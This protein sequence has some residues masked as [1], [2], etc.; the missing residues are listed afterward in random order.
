MRFFLSEEEFRLLSDDAAAVAERA[1]SALRDLHR[2][3]DTVRAESDA[4]SIAAEQN[5][6]LLEQRYEALSSDLAR[7]QAENA[8]LSESLEQRLSEIAAALAEKHQLHIKAIAKDGDIER[9]SL[10]AQELGKSKQHL[11]DLLEQ[12]DAE[13]REKNATVQSY[14]DKIINMTDSATEKEARLLDLEAEC[15]RCKAICIRVNQEKELIEKHNAWLNEELSTK[16]NSLIE[17]RKTHL[18][19]V[20]DMSA[21]LSEYERQ[22]NECSSSLKHS[23]ERVGELEL[24]NASIEKELFSSKD[25]AAAKEEQLISELA[26]VRKL[27]ELHKERSEEWSKKS[28]E[29]EGVIK[30]LE[31]HLSQHEN[32]YKD[33]LEK[34]SSLRKN[35]EKDAADMKEKLEKYE[36][37]LDRARKSNELSLVPSSFHSD[38]SLEVLPVAQTTT[39]EN[40]HILVPKI[41]FGISGT[42]LAASLLRDGWSLAKMYEKYQEA[43]DALQHEKWGRKNAE[44]ALERV[45]HE[46]E[47]KAEMIL[48]ERA[49]HGRMI[50][51]YNL[52][53]QKLQ[54]SLIDYDNFENTIRNLKVTILLKECQDIQVRCGVTSFYADNTLISSVNIDDPDVGRSTSEYPVS[55]KDIHGLVEQ[56]VQLRGQ[57]LSLSTEIENKEVDLKDTFEFQLQ[58]ITAEATSKVETVLKRSEEQNQMI[59][60][61]HGSVAMYRRLYEEEQ[62]MH[63]STNASTGKFEGVLKFT[64]RDHQSSYLLCSYFKAFEAEDG[65]KDLM[66][67]F[68]GSQDVSKK[69]YEQL[70]ERA[71]NLEEDLAKF[72]SEVALLRSERDK[73]A[74]EAI[75]AKD[76]LDDLKKEIERQPHT[77][78]IC[79]EWEIVILYHVNF[80]Y[81]FLTVITVKLRNEA[82]VGSTRNLELTQLVVDFQKR[83]RESSNSVQEAEENARKLSME[84]S[85]LKHEKE[86]ISN[87]EKRALDE[88]RNLSERVHRL[89]A[90]LDTIQSSEEV[91]E[92]SRAIGMKKLEEYSKRVEREWAEA[93]GEL[94]E[95]RDRLR[96]L[97]NDKENILETSIKQFQEMKKE[98]A[99][100]WGAVASAESRAAVAEARCSEFELRMKTAEEKV[101]KGDNIYEHRVFSPNEDTGDIRRVREELE[102]LREE[103][104]AN[105]DYM[106]QY[107]EIAHTNEIA[108][109]QIES[110]YETYKIEAESVKKALDDEVFSLKD[111][112]SELEKKYVLKCEEILSL[113]EVKDR[114]ISALFAETS[115]LRMEIAQK[116]TQIDALETQLSSL[117]GDLDRE[118]ERWRTTQHNYERQVILQS[119]TIQELTKTSNE[120]SLMQCEIAKLKEVSDMQKSENE[121]LK[122]SWENDKTTLNAM[123]DEAEKKYNELN[124]QNKILH[125]QLESLHIRFAEKERNSAGLSS[126]SVDL[127]AESDLHN[128]ITYLRRSKEIAETEIT[129]LK[130][131]KSRL[132]AQLDSALKASEAAKELLH[133]RRENNRALMFNDEEFKAL[134][135]QIRE[136][137]LLRESNVQLRE[138]N[139]HNFEECQRYRDE[140][141]KA[142][143]DAET[144]EN[145]LREK[146]LQY[147]YSQ[148]DVNILR[149]E[150]NHLNNRIAEVL[151]KK[152]EMEIEPIKKLVSDKQEIISKLTE[153]LAKSELD[154][155]E[156]ER[157]IN[158]AVQIEGTIKTESERQKKYI[159][160]LKKKNENITKENVELNQ[161]KETLLKEIEEFKSARKTPGETSIEQATKE[162]DTRI[163][164]LEKILER[165]REENKKEKQKRQNTEKKIFEVIQRVSKEKKSLTEELSRH[166]LAVEVLKS[167][168]VATSQLPSE[169]TLIEQYDQYIQ[170][171]T[172][173]ENASGSMADD[174]LG[175]PPVPVTETSASEASVF[176]SVRQVPVQVARPLTSPVKSAEEKEKGPVIGRPTTAATRKIPARK[177]VRPRLEP[178]E[179]PQGDNSASGMEGSAPTEDDKAGASHE[180]EPSS[181]ILVGHSISSSRKSLSS[182]SE[183]KDDV[184]SK[185]EVGADAVPL[186][187]KKDSDAVQDLISLAQPVPPNHKRPISTTEDEI[188]TAAAAPPL[189]K[190]KD[191]DMLQDV[192]QDLIDEKTI[193]LSAEDE[194]AET[195]LPSS[196][197]V[198]DLQSPL[199]DME[200]DQVPALPNEEIV[201]TMEEDDSFAREEQVEQQNTL[202]ESTH[203]DEIQGE[204]ETAPEDF[205]DNSKEA[206]E[207]LDDSVKN[208]GVKEISQPPPTD[209][210][211]REEGELPDEPEEQQE[212]G[213]LGEGQRESTPSD[214]AGLGDEAGFSIDTVPPDQ[215]GIGEATDEVPSHNNEDQFA[216]DSLQ[217]TLALSSA[218]REG[219]PSSTLVSALAQQQIASSTADTDESRVGSVISI[220]QRAKENAQ[221]RQAGIATQTSA[222]RG[223]GWAAGGH[224]GTRAMPRARRG[225][226]GRGQG[227][228]EQ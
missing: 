23:T 94:Q 154:L 115:D 219:S 91:R 24:R 216:P 90:S 1:E 111:K 123:K 27:A 190:S 203:K 136:I 125:S 55:F 227:F 140:A 211:D 86:I 64:L 26:T 45:L 185:D 150:I 126:Q 25:A 141:Q 151:L 158:D 113:T 108:L 104:R 95:E 44:A 114:E 224:R 67:L 12:K 14:L 66:L 53:N 199:E 31:S 142:R 18:E 177:L 38:S 99:D 174:G 149:I 205:L 96:V 181:D 109:K 52:M 218:T 78:N 191:T 54:Q 88:I 5:C 180:P 170:A 179:V 105:K 36:A 20:A 128:V 48:D 71:K 214:G 209:E 121:I 131:E 73:M 58:K 57:V 156:K 215:S 221:L 97:T 8:Q 132:Q 200:T 157:R 186:P 118:H 208:E 22:I 19:V 176:P 220:A 65:K 10:E 201:D 204:E 102:R 145:L 74:L 133:S 167:G 117:K 47:A 21:K 101:G 119:E 143:V 46:I 3:V 79:K 84:V 59:E 50:E 11:L 223:R 160:V 192:S 92:N 30:A 4:A 110:A 161:E 89:Q 49:E 77:C 62:K 40:N 116:V 107:K 137:N 134:Q 42:A 130:Q 194:P 139:K 178:P 13:I 124:E 168:A 147:E 166:K 129:L 80:L 163:Q 162:K 81:H 144:F 85:I 222:S 75:F 28:G 196:S 197:N 206:C 172:Q 183:Q 87:S 146:Q 148:N 32:E 72:R 6:A 103:A 33:K 187:T 188:D 63:T 217:N 210:D 43:A 171:A 34:E 228:G 213:R 76:Q 35:I 193:L 56:N 15:S 60:S 173:L 93:K 16:V 106:I 83:L 29:L 169:S 122:S 153:N 9:L 165:E 195:L 202:D 159:S 17:E 7:V 226:G 152:F 69:A 2:Q 182:M 68:E 207:L 51:A 61:L 212:G 189:K 138:E 198:S 100:A 127:K 175:N 155:A 164:M 135:I 82:N 37:E 225:R 41:P 112:V 120:L 39:S 70:A 184:L 98:L